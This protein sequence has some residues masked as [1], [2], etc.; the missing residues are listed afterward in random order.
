MMDEILIGQAEIEFMKGN[1]QKSIDLSKD[2]LARVREKG[3]KQLEIN[4][5]YDIAVCLTELDQYHEA[6]EIL[7]KCPTMTHPDDDTFDNYKVLQ[8]MIVLDSKTG[9]SANAFL[10]QRKLEQ[11]TAKKHSPEQ[12]QETSDMMFQAEMQQLNMK[13]TLL[14]SA[15]PE[16]NN[17]TAK[18]NTVL[19]VLILVACG[20]IIFFA[21][22]RHS[23]KKLKFEKIRFSDEETILIEEQK[24]L[25]G[26]SQ[27]LLQNHESLQKIN[28]H[29]T[30]SSRSK[31]ELFKTISHDLQKPL[32]K[33]QQNLTNL[34]TNI[35]EDQFR[36]ATAVLTTMVGDISLLL[37]NLLQWS[38]YQSQG[39][40]AKPQYTELI[41]LVNDVVGH[42]K[43]SAAEKKITISNTLEQSIFVYADEEMVKSMLKTILQN[44]VRLSKPG[45]MIT[46]YG[47]KDKQNGWLQVNYSGKMP[48]KRTFLEQQK[49]VKYGSKTTE[50]GK[51]II[52][53]WLLCRTLMQANK[54]NISVEDISTDSFYII[55]NFPLEETARLTP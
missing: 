11:I 1:F 17:R 34:M 45:A 36:Q 51:A 18:T 28:Q 29:L 48:L 32:I 10:L 30:A 23:F 9:N 38:K 55:L 54:G 7:E 37:E 15:L 19:I 50:P 40:H 2:V 5:L 26:K 52:L 14:Q 31:T 6:R 41:A 12:L 42:Q 53:G 13:L 47:N 8:L 4:C 21:L 3:Q 24:N 43:Y 25:S 49:A 33:L 35:G 39:I 44:I 20:E 16:Q 46:I 22:L 27:S